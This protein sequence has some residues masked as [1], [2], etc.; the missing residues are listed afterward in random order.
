MLGNAQLV[1]REIFHFSL[2]QN[3]A[4]FGLSVFVF[5]CI[6]LS[7]SLI[8]FLVFLNL[9]CCIFSDNLSAIQFPFSSF[10][11]SFYAFPAS[12]LSLCRLLSQ[13]SRCNFFLFSFAKSITFSF[14]FLLLICFCFFLLLRSTF[15]L[16]GFGARSLPFKFISKQSPH[17]PTRLLP[18]VQ[19][20][21][22]TF[23]HSLFLSLSFSLSLS[24][25]LYFSLTVFFQPAKHAFLLH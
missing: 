2:F 12:S 15:C 1:S 10:A 9:L 19:K 4:V 7:R 11:F 3:F 18:H 25:N 20:L 23:S 17:D 16:V 5:L 24:L 22:H 21:L 14:L 13:R 6:C 8:V